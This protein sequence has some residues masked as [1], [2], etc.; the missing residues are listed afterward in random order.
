VC[1]YNGTEVFRADLHPAISANPF[2]VFSTVAIES[3]PRVLLDGDKRL[4]GDGVRDYCLGAR[5]G[6]PPPPALEPSR[7][8]RD[9]L[10]DPVMHGF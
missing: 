3:A 6:P 2:I 4:L 1:T 10:D 8:T 7:G 9:G 5:Y